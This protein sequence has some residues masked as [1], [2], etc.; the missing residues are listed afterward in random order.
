MR[1]SSTQSVGQLIEKC[2]KVDYAE[3]ATD[4]GGHFLRRH[5]VGEQQRAIPLKPRISAWES[6]CSTAQSMCTKYSPTAGYRP[7]H[8]LTRR[9]CSAIDWSH[10]LHEWQNAI[11]ETSEITYCPWPET[12][13]GDPSLHEDARTVPSNNPTRRINSSYVN[14]NW[15]T[16][17]EGYVRASSLS[18]LNQCVCYCYIK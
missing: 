2:A 6:A 17:K 1:R 8:S 16:R 3:C 12:V 5:S 15:S 18:Q 7:I 14:V 9:Y 10:W 13:V 11:L 4:S